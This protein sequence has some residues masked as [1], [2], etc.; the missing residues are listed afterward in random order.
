MECFDV[1]L[2]MPI[3]KITLVLNAKDGFF[4]TH[5][6]EHVLRKRCVLIVLVF[7]DSHENLRGA[8]GYTRSVKH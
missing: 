5:C 6:F 2:S 7:I 3:G 4:Y 1:S 8:E